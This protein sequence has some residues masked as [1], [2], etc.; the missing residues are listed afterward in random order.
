MKIELDVHT[1]TLASGH[2][3]S[4]IM[5]PAYPEAATPFIFATSMSY[6]VGCTGLS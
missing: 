2:A 5:R 6:L 3:L 1:H 4:P